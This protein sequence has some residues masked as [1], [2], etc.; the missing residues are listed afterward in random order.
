M[1]R[2]LSFTLP[3][4][5]RLLTG[6]DVSIDDGTIIQF[7]TFRRYFHSD[8]VPTWLRFSSRLYLI[9]VDDL[10]CL[11]KMVDIAVACESAMSNK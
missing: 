11:K 7:P 2:I 9:N 3:H 8:R 1:G 4:T 5:C 10:V 6:D